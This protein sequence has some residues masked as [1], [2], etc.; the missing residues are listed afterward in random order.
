[1]HSLLGDLVD[2]TRSDCHYMMYSDTA[3]FGNYFFGNEVFTRQMNYCGVCLPT[4]YSHYL[5]DV[6]VIRG[7]NHLYNHM[8]Q[9]GSDSVAMNSNIGMQMV[10]AGRRIPRSELA[11]RV[12]ALDA[13]Y[14]KHM[15]NKWF[16]DAEPSF[17]NWG[18]CET[19]AA[20]GTYK[21]FKINTMST[22][23]NTHHSLFQ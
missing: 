21:Y 22:V 10:K 18:P 11:K 19:V 5:N 12:A 6:E 4:I 16:Y 2:V 15:C 17:T 23:T 14:M 7:R 1:M 9:V 20:C 8:M 13:Y 3:L